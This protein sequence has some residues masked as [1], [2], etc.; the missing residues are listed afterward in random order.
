MNFSTK[1]E[2][3][4]LWNWKE[5][6]SF[7]QWDEREKSK[8]PKNA[9]INNENWKMYSEL[10][11]LMLFYT[12][13]SFEYIYS[14]SSITSSFTTFP[15]HPQLY[16]KTSFF[17]ISRLCKLRWKDSKFKSNCESRKIMYGR[18]V[19]VSLNETGKLENPMNNE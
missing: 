14:R 5:V 4:E 15:Y 16:E 17:R 12:Q 10:R 19:K 18:W 7:V 8:I 9:W 1:L 13:S 3:F 6:E 11:N 2:R